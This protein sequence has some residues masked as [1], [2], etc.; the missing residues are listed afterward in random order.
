MVGFSTTYIVPMARRTF[1]APWIVHLHGGSALGW[2]LLL[3]FQA[4][5]VK[6]QRT[7]LHR[8]LGKAALPLALVVWV[9]GVLTAAW[10]AKR[11]FPTLGSAASSN[12]AGTTVGLGLFFALVVA[13][14]LL[15]KRPDWHKRLLV[16]ATIQVLWPAI[17][18]WR[19]LLPAIPNPDL[20]LAIVA[21]YTP[22]AVAAYRDLRVYGRVHPVWLFVAPALVI[23]QSLEFAYFDQGPIR[24][25]GAWL[26]PLL[27]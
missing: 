27:S 14:L 6:V 1:E 20:W 8:R 7:R 26:Y 23:E 16:L 15:R 4:R 10:A 5:L 19:H 12:L 9:S 13:A 21:A 3:I 11:D 17:F 25:F 22:I 2:V 24:A 18:R